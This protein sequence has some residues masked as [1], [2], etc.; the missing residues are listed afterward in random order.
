MP[1]LIFM[2]SIIGIMPII[3]INGWILTIF[4]KWFFIPIFNLPQLT[5][6]VSIGIILTIRFLIGKTKYTKTTEPS[7]WG[8]FII[9]LF[10]GILNSIFMLGIG[11]IVHLFI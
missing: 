6:A 8:I 11:W 7:N 2:I 1:I 10:E 5:I 9:T 3:I 4:W